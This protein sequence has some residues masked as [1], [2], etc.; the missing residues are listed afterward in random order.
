ML[1]IS[2][3]P[4]HISLRAHAY[5]RACTHIC[6]RVPRVSTA[7]AREQSAR[8]LCEIM[9]FGCAIRARRINT[10]AYLPTFYGP[11]RYHGRAATDRLIVI[12]S[13]NWKNSSKHRQRLQ[14]SVIFSA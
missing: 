5:V 14:S 1:R 7:K 10:V 8:D 13:V 3:S 2:W 9:R 6:G 11:R 4:F 12:V